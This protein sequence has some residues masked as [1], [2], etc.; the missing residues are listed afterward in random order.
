MRRGFCN[1]AR[2]LFRAAG[3]L[4][5]VILAGCAGLQTPP[6]PQLA[7]R[8]VA[9]ARSQLGVS[10]RYGG[11][12][13]RGFDCSGLVQYVYRRAAGIS[14]PRT[15]LR[16]YQRTR[17]VSLGNESPSDLVFFSTDRSGPSHVGIY[18]GKGLFIHAPGRGDGVKISNANDRYWRDR[19]VG[20]RRV[21]R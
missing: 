6:D 11:T 10:Y 16:Q 21:L 13:P 2:G 1:G 12:T 8:V 17:P 18:L 5:A 19:F 9:E 3:A 7:Q 15:S 4:A 20:V 14:L